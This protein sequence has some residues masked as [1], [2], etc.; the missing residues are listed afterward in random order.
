MRIRFVL[1]EPRVPENIGAS[2]RALKTMGFCELVL[3]NPC[4]WKE[5]KAK[6]VAHGSAEILEN[7]AVFG[8]LAEAI[9]E[10]DLAIAT[11]AKKRSVKEDFVSAD[12]LSSFLTAK[13]ESIKVVSLVF[14][15]EESGLTNGEMKLCD[16]ISTIRMAA[17]Y[18]SLNLSQAVMIYAYELAG[19]HSP[20]PAEMKGTGEGSFRAMRSKVTEVLLRAGIN[21]N[22]NRYGRILERVSFMGE[23]DVH[24]V[25]SICNMILEKQGDGNH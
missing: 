17:L 11:S 8:S 20:G 4:G 14:G 25:H 6:W 21:E 15:R 2:A 10:S 3:V 23:D 13:G 1:V 12:C 9:G 18:P 5:G 16:L 22:D 7:A 19:L 24:L